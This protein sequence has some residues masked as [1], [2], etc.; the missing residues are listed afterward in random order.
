MHIA[1]LI[2]LSSRD[3]I[4][5]KVYEQA[6]VACGWAGAVMIKANLSIW[7]GAGAKTARSA[8]KANADGLAD[9]WTDQR[10]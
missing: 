8:E 1:V 5:N 4:N 2:P 9:G 10:T 7:A 3:L 6:E